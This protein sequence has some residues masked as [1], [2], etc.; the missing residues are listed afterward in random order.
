VRTAAVALV[1][2]S[3]ALPASAH[4]SIWIANGARD[5]VLRVDSRGYAEVRWR[6]ASGGSR[7]LLVPP[8]GKLLPG[9]RIAGRDVSRPASGAA[10]PMRVLVRRTPDG[11]LWALQSWRVLPRGPVE[12]HLSRWRGAPTRIEPDTPCCPESRLRGTVVFGGRPVY[13]VSPTPEG[14]RIRLIAYVDYARRGG[15]WARAS[16]VF[17]RP[18]LG[19]FALFLRSGWRSTRYRVTAAGPNRG[20]TLAPDAR[21]VVP[22][23]AS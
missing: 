8:R 21:V 19:S 18:P 15:G 23:S 3:P 20:T 17:L 11:R 7:T 4:A 9:G 5:P 12:L 10:I 16:G 14:K 2:V 1:L 22:A 13:G 6:D